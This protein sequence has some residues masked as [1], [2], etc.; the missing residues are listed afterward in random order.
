LYKGEER[1]VA[2]DGFKLQKARFFP[3]L[4]LSC[5]VGCLW[6]RHGC[7]V[8]R[9]GTSKDWKLSYNYHCLTPILAG[10]K[11]EVDVSI[12]GFFLLFSSKEQLRI[13]LLVLQNSAKARRMKRSAELMRTRK[14]R[15]CK[16]FCQCRIRAEPARHEWSRRSHSKNVL[17]PG[18]LSPGD[19]KKAVSEKIRCGTGLCH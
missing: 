16:H 2:I 5:A 7:Q 10:D 1:G 15:W 19:S 18:Q 17:L 4:S 3:V 8:Y 14:L 13:V 6:Q 9:S 11:E 12:L